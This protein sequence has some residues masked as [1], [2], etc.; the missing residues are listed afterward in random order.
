M[1]YFEPELLRPSFL[2]Q[3]AEVALKAM[4]LWSTRAEVEP[5]TA[6]L[7]PLYGVRAEEK[8]PS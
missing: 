6:S 4:R 8:T 7:P 5:N 3:L 1:N 2:P